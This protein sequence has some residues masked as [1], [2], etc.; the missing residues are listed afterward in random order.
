MVYSTSTCPYCQNIIK[1]QK[2]PSLQ[3]ANPFE[4]CP[5]CGGVYK[6]SLKKEWLTFSP[7]KRFL[8]FINIGVWARGFLLSL[9]IPVLFSYSIDESQSLILLLIFFLCFISYMS[10]GWFLHKGLSEDAIKQS[11]DRT[12]NYY[13]VELLKKSGYKIYPIKN[14]KYG[15]IKEVDSTMNQKDFAIADKNDI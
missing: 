2:N 3:I 9:F 5:W 4:Q 7:I 1:R 14:V 10:F 15:D 11:I 8:F 6:N 12:R 13:Y